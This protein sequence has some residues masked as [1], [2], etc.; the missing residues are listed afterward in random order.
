MQDDELVKSPQRQAGT[1]VWENM[2][3]DDNT[4]GICELQLIFNEAK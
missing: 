3:E 1:Q 2:L 4:E